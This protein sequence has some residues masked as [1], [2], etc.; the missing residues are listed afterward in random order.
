MMEIRGRD[1][2]RATDLTNKLDDTEAI[3]DM[4]LRGPNVAKD[5][6]VA[7]RSRFWMAFMPQIGGRTNRIETA[8]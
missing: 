5:S 2:I 6:F 3:E 7:V 1:V 4:A 8:R